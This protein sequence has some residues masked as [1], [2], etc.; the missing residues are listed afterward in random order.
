MTTFL[1][2]SYDVLEE[3]L[4]HKKNL[5]LKIYTGK[6]VTDCCIEIL[7][8]AERLE[9]YGAFKPDHLGYITHIF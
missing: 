6:N 7:V 2:G 5:K 4:T 9:I 8:D 3:T 1:S